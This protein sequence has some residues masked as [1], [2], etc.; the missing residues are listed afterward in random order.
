MDTPD[1][2]ALFTVE[3]NAAVG[4]GQEGM[5]DQ[6]LNQRERGKL[7]AQVA[8]KAGRAGLSGTGEPSQATI[9]ESTGG[10]GRQ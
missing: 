9:V 3:A 1:V 8:T 10:E 4:I 7:A 2:A 6:W 5:L